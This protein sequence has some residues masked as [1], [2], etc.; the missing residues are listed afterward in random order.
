MTTDEFKQLIDEYFLQNDLP[1]HSH[2]MDKIEYTDLLGVPS[3][4]TGNVPS[5]D[6]SDGA[7]TISSGT[8]TIDLGGADSVVKQYSS[9]SITGTGKLAF[10]N[11]HANGTLIVFYCS[12]DVNI[13]SSNDPAIDLKG[14]GGD[15]GVGGTGD[16]TDGT[17]LVI[18][19]DALITGANATKGLKGIDANTGAS[20]T[21]GGVAATSFTQY[22]I[23]PNELIQLA[24]GI[25][26]RGSSGAGG[27][28]GGQGGNGGGNAGDGGAGGGSLIIYCEGNLNFTGI[29]DADGEAGGDGV[30]GGDSDYGGSGGGGGGGGGTVVLSANTITTNTGTIRTSGGNGGDGSNGTSSSTNNNG[31]AAGSGGANGWGDDSGAG[32]D[33]GYDGAHPATN[34]GN[35]NGTAGGTG[36][37]KGTSGGTYGS[38][39][40]NGGGGG[41][42]GGASGYSKVG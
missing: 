18:G 38:G 24:N 25:F 39:A 4:T 5:G 23:A 1:D 17:D 29:I 14:I 13:S 42:G 30:V 9:I 21:A 36:G 3:T 35:G 33:G 34:G 16:G 20:I 26:L 41:G 40:T 8:T 37:T 12:G 10:S 19:S 6:G 32:G 31:A 28:G 27:G 11:S 15:A 22:Y 7:L 2:T